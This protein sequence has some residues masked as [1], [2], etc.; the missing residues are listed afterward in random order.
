MEKCDNCDQMISSQN[1]IVHRASCHRFK[2]KCEVCG[3]VVSAGLREDHQISHITNDPLPITN[4]GDPSILPKETKS[5][6]FPYTTNLSPM[7]PMDPIDPMGPMGPMG[8]DET[9]F[10]ECGMK[11]PILEIEVHTLICRYNKPTNI[12]KSP[13]HQIGKCDCCNRS[14][15]DIIQE[16][17]MKCKHPEINSFNCPICNKVFGNMKILESHMFTHD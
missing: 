6:S 1:I 9:Y 14:F 11:V 2:Y 17:I 8:L 16:H 15:N 3:I 5:N 13:H 7:D 12:N 10:C 4:S